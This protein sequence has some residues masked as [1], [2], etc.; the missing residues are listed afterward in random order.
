[1]SRVFILFVITIG[2][3]SCSNFND[4]ISRSIASELYGN[5]EKYRCLI[6]HSRGDFN[7]DFDDL[8]NDEVSEWSQFELSNIE[9]SYKGN[10]LFL[11]IE[12]AGLVLKIDVVLGNQTKSYNFKIDS[13]NNEQV[14]IKNKKLNLQSVLS[15][16]CTFF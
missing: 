7:S 5:I 3:I 6:N 12:K 13:I 8:P 2:I 9:K 1:M 10:Q 15:F 4:K 16:Q 14:I 11:Y